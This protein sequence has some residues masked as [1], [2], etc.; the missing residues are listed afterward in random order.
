MLINVL[1]ALSNLVALGYAGEH[2]PFLLAPMTASFLYHLAETK[3]GLPGVFF[4]NRFTLQLLVLDRAMAILSALYL[5]TVLIDQGRVHLFCVPKVL[6]TGT[7]A[8]LCLAISELA[9]RWFAVFHILW[10]VLAFDT[11]A[12]GYSLCVNT[13]FD[14]ARFA[15]VAVTTIAVTAVFSFARLTT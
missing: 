1:V 5:C 3:H 4:L 13:K 10:H 9:D 15:R 7:V 12:F 2:Q 11:L 14:L 6:I 8:L